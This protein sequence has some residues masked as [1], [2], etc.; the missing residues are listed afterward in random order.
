MAKEKRTYKRSYKNLVNVFF[1]I[2]MFLL[3]MLVGCYATWAWYCKS[4]P[5]SYALFTVQTIISV[6]CAGGLTFLA[7]S[8]FNKYSS[9]EIIDTKRKKTIF[10]LTTFIITMLFSIVNCCAMCCMAYYSNIC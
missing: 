1:T 7:M 4:I 10:A 6:I 5:L 2:T 9:K 8:G 3:N